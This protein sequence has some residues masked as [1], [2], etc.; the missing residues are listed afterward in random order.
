LRRELDV[1]AL[2]DKLP[3]V[4]EIDVTALNIHDS[5]HL[6]DVVLPEGVEVRATENFAI[7]AMMPPVVEVEP[8][9]EEALVA[10]VEGEPVAE[11]E[12]APPSDAEAEKE[13]D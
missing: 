9:E 10:G 7:V 8:V 12:D 4:I 5:I 13:G 11:G 6:E 2:P 1:R 3:E